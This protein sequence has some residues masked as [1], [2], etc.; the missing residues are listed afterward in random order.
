M[1][2]WIII[3]F[4]PALIS[5][6]LVAT[7]KNKCK[8]KKMCEWFDKLLSVNDLQFRKC[9]NRILE[10]KLYE[11][12][13]GIIASGALI[14]LISKT[15]SDIKATA[16]NTPEAQDFSENKYQWL[17]TKLQPNQVT[18]SYST[19][20]FTLYYRYPSPSESNVLRIWFPQDIR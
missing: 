13:D 2:G 17:M 18:Y 6:L 14:H 5:A 16:I 8:A 20:S 1:I 10:D 12:N 9:V 11:Y 19:S 15:N 4:F 7:Y 3:L